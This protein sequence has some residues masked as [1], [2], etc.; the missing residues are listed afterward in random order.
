MSPPATSVLDLQLLVYEEC[1]RPSA[2]AVCRLTVVVYDAL[3][4]LS[5]TLLLLRRHSAHQPAEISFMLFRC[6]CGGGSRS[7]GGNDGNSFFNSTKVTTKENHTRTPH[8]HI[9]H[10]LA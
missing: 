9:A 5:H 1:M 10:T 3:S 4:Y 2:T 6:V 8:V 7:G